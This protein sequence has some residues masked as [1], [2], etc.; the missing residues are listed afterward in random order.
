MVNEGNWVFTTTTGRHVEPRAL[1]RQFERL[2]KKAG[3]KRIVFH[4]L[5]H[6]HAT[7]MLAAGIHPK[8][9]AE[10]LGHS[11]VSLTMD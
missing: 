6:T 8:A 9:A 3:V 4:D 5:R 11:R 1:T 7:L 2:I 10:R